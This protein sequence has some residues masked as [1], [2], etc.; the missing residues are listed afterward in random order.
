VRRHC[1]LALTL[2]VPA[3]AGCG[4]TRTPRP[5]L[6]KPA[7]PHGV[8][9]VAYPRSGIKFKAPA[10]WAVSM[11]TAP[12]VAT[13]T[14]G[15][16]I[17]AVWRYK[18]AAPVPGT[19]AALDQTRTALIRA[20]EAKDPSLRVIRSH[21][22]RLHGAPTVVL[23]AVEQISGYERR[24]RSVHL[25]GYGSEFVVDEYAPTSE[26]SAVDHVVFSPLRRSLTLIP[27]DAA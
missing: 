15:A 4:N 5:G 14:S 3:V 12:M 13:V 7:A 18:Q 2:V 26:F 23:D 16:A 21:L 24:V 22:G 10:N 17:V 1:L 19:S 25:F 8:R 11:Q 6:V 20:A 27:A 9:S